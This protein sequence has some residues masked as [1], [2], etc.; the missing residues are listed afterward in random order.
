MRL[1]THIKHCL[2]LSIFAFCLGCPSIAL[3]DDT[4]DSSAL[5]DRYTQEAVKAFKAHDMNKAVEL[6]N[7][8]LLSNNK[9]SP[10]IYNN[11]AV[12]YIN[13]SNENFRQGNSPAA[14]ADARMAY[15][16]LHYSLRYGD[17]VYPRIIFPKHS[18]NEATAIMNLGVL[19]GVMTT[20]PVDGKF[21]LEAAQALEKKGERPQALV[22]YGQAIDAGLTEATPAF[23]RLAKE[24]GFSK[25]MDSEVYIKEMTLKIKPLW[26]PIRNEV[27]YTV[28]TAF[29]IHNS[30][31][32]TDIIIKSSSGVPGADEAARK[33]LQSANLQPPPQSMF[34]KGQESITSEFIF[35]YQIKDK[36]EAP[37]KSEP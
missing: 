13:R 6:F 27:P 8:A 36:P 15:Y 17:T 12:A 30:G 37:K 10:A 14:L 9:P 4:V 26:V 7:Q 19:Y 21:H 18:E 33:A 35:D 22:E 23:Q 31:H 3:S 5:A 20:I 32:I 2:L 1:F 28:V 16:Y 29:K 11:L 24:L 34:L 25:A